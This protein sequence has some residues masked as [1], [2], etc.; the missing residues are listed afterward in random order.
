MLHFG[1][2][3]AGTIDLVLVRWPSGSTTEYRGVSRDSTIH[4]VEGQ[5]SAMEVKV[6]R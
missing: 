3:A 1:L 4:L 5:I 6:D 2:G